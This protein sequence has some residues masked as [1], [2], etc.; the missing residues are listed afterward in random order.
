MGEGSVR[1]LHPLR[2]DAQHALHDLDAGDSGVLQTYGDA[3]QYRRD[4][5]EVFEEV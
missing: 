3:E 5:P 1:D 2:V 4:L